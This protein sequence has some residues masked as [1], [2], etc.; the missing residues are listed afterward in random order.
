MKKKKRKER[1]R[2][3]ES[4]KKRTSPG[5][6]MMSEMPCTPWRRTSSASRNASESGVA[7]PTTP[8]R[9]RFFFLFVFC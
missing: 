6:V 2:K 3:N 8:R 9:L 7:S 5:I 4:I 1:E